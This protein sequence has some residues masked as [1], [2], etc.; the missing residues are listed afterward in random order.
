MP[1]TIKHSSI[2]NFLILL[3]MIAP[4]SPANFAKPL[5]IIANLLIILRFLKDRKIYINYNRIFI[6][7][8]M[9][10]GIIISGLQSPQDLIRFFIILYIIFKFPFNKINLNKKIIM[11]FSILILL[12]LGLTQIFIYFRVDW[13]ISYR[14]VWYA[15]Q[16]SHI[17]DYQNFFD[18]TKIESFSELIG[19]YRLGGLFHNPNL[20]A[21]IVLLNFFI[22]EV[23]YSSL[24]RK[25]KYIYLFILSFSFI[26]LIL[27]YSRT[28]ILGFL[29]YQL[30]KCVDFK[31]LIQFKINKKVLVIFIASMLIGLYILKDVLTVFDPGQ[32]GYIKFEI[33]FNNL[34]NSDLISLFFGGGHDVMLDS[35]LGGWIGAFGFIGFAGYL[36]LLSNIVIINNSLFP[37]IIA[38]IF[39]SIGNTIFYGLLTANICL[40]YLIITSSD[41]T[42]KLHTQSNKL[43]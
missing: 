19:N 20:L 30:L 36:L 37:F 8:L 1:L 34:I 33:L 14:D 35:D 12:Y 5:V 18:P 43:I 2:D 25:N 28:A 6:F 11:F 40:A 32:S 31:K 16:Y 42:K 4:I 15:S 26:S 10:P 17:F 13:L 41:D 21:M 38:L 7:L 22:F 23:C 27:T 39:M 24:R 3:L 29:I 9:L